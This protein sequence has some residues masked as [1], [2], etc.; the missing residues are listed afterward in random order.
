MRGIKLYIS[1]QVRF[2]NKDGEEKTAYFNIKAR[3]IT[4]EH[5]IDNVI[6]DLFTSQV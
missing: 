4:N 6:S 1:L 5:D 3:E 2:F